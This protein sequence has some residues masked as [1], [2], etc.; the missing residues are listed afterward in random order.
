MGEGVSKTAKKI[1]TS[2]MDTFEKS[3]KMN[4]E[5]LVA[6]FGVCVKHVQRARRCLRLLNSGSA[7]NPLLIK[8][9][10]DEGCRG[11]SVS[12]Y[13]EFLGFELDNV[14]Q[15]KKKPVFSCP[16]QL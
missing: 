9:L 14:G 8:D 10:A 13:P 2:F 16:E 1:P 5:Q 15:C 4:L 6:A 12:D 3:A 11:W 7:S